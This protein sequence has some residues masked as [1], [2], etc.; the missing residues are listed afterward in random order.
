MRRGDLPSAVPERSQ[1]HQGIIGQRHCA[2]QIAALHGVLVHLIGDPGTGSFV[3][4]SL[5][6]LNHFIS[7]I[8]R[9]LRRYY[10]FMGHIVG[11]S[12]VDQLN[13][14]FLCRHIQH[15]VGLIACSLCRK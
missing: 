9:G 4:G 3:H 11:D 12:S 8:G 2:F 6:G 13:S 7:K 10:F 5:S 1:F 15:Q 14:I